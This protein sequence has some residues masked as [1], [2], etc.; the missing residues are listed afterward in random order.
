MAAL[1]SRSV[2]HADAHGAF[3][4]VERSASGLRWVE[5][6]APPRANIATA[7]AQKHD[8][9]QLLARVLA[10][11]GVTPETVQD[12]LEPTLKQLM[13]DPSSLRDM[14]TGAARFAEA[15]VKRQEITVFGDY[16][17]DGASSAALV[18]RFVRAHGLE[19]QIY[20]PDRITEG[21]GP[22][23]QAFESIVADGTQLI[24]TVDCGTAAHEPI[25]HAT[26]RGA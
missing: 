26:S 1:S 2:P 7:I 9:P 10:A 21:Y 25:E 23:R 5:R 17:V 18:A 16:D 4:N 24:I 19:P 6:L 15:I 12:F 20:I 14:D 8:V 22:N 13:P 11:R 3:L